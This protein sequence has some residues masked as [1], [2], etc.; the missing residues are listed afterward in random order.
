MKPRLERELQKILKEENWKSARGN[1]RA[2]FETQHKR[3]EILYGGI[4][5]LCGT[6][7][8]KIESI[9]NFREHH[10][11]RLG[12]YWEEKGIKDLQTRISIFRV[13]ANLWL[14]KRGMIRES[15]R[16]VRNPG[17]VRRRCATKKDKTWTGQGVDVLSTIRHVAEIDAR[18]AIVLE[19]MY[20]YGC[21]VKEALLLRPHL[22]DKKELLAVTRGAKGG[23]HRITEIIVAVQRDVLERAKKFAENKNSSMIPSDRKYNSYRKHVYRVCNRAGIG[24][25]F[26]FVPHGLRHEYANQKYQEITGTKSP[27]KGGKMGAVDP[28][29]DDYARTDIAENLGHSRKRIASAYLGAVQPPRKNIDVI[30]TTDMPTT[31]EIQ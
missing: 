24:R 25:K 31:G 23:K 15:E 13:F 26:G 1:G 9:R 16:Y 3:A 22:A 6:L 2:S 4:N 18:V 27:I 29:L 11:K 10:L 19:I 14:R 28:V 20:A 21:R 17:S 5:T 7:K 8:C 12:H 30:H